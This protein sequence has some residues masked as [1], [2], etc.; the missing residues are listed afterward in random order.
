MGYLIQHRWGGAYFVSGDSFQGKPY[1]STWKQDHKYAWVFE[2]PE[3]AKLVAARECYAEARQL[4]IV[5][6]P[7]PQIKV[8]A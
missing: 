6:R 1:S 5:R 2:S 8:A 4:V 3:L 7:K